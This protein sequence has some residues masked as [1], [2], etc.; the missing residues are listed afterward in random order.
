[1]QEKFDYRNQ[2]H[3]WNW[4]DF[5]EIY[6]VEDTQTLKLYWVEETSHYED[7]FV[8]SKSYEH[9]QDYL[10][11]SEGMGCGGEDYAHALPIC[12]IPEELIKKYKLKQKTRCNGID[13]VN[14][15]WAQIDI[16]KDLGCEIIQEETPRAI[17][18]HGQIFREG[19]LLDHVVFKHTL[20]KANRLN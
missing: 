20:K 14:G 8:I 17:K 9:A 13:G 16:L 4:Q 2:D 19:S 7:W 12:V 6:D 11:I 5:P 3:R 15:D 1:M 10:L 18:I